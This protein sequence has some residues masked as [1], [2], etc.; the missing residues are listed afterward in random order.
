MHSCMVGTNKKMCLIIGNGVDNFDSSYIFLH[1][2]YLQH[3]E[4][5]LAHNLTTLY[6]SLKQV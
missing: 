3:F 6:F 1:I 5:V 2:Y 4:F